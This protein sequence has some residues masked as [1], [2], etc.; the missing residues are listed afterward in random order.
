MKTTAPSGTISTRIGQ[1]AFSQGKYSRG[2]YTTSWAGVG[3]TQITVLV[4]AL[5]WPHPMNLPASL[6]VNLPVPLITSPDSYGI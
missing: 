3:F 2:E 5:A 1:N 6:S 4:T